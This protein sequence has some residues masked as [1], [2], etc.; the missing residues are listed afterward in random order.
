MIIIFCQIR[1]WRFVSQNILISW[2]ELTYYA[3]AMVGPSSPCIALSKVQRHDQ[4]SSSLSKKT[5]HIVAMTRRNPEKSRLAPKVIASSGDWKVLISHRGLACTKKR[6]GPA[7]HPLLH[8]SQYGKSSILEDEC[9]VK[10]LQR[11]LLSVTRKVD[12]GRPGKTLNDSFYV[13][14]C[15]RNSERRQALLRCVKFHFLKLFFR[16]GQRFFLDNSHK[17]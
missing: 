12:H 17:L 10:R 16:I 9:A 14:R 3:S 15:T 4:V 6:K 2:I 1:P 13:S 11:F 7:R 5:H 8:Y